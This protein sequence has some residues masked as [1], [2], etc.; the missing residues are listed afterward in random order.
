MAARIVHVLKVIEIEIQDR[1]AF[2]AGPSSG[3]RFFKRLDKDATIGEPRENIEVCHLNDLLFRAL[4][5]GDVVETL[6]QIS[7]FAECH[8]RGADVGEDDRAILPFERNVGR[9]PYL[10]S[11]QPFEIDPHSGHRLGRMHIRHAERKEFVG[12]ITE[13]IA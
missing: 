8:R 2:G 4:A 3:D 10:A 7:P 12:T 6:E 13:Q 11:A 1:K 5:R 9:S